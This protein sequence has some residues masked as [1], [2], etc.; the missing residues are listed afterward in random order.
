MKCHR[1]TTWLALGVAI[2]ASLG[3]ATGEMGLWLAIGAGIGGGL[4]SLTYGLDAQ[5]DKRCGRK[6]EQG[7]SDG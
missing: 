3:A 7:S 1:G 5:R 6:D 4:M 2:G